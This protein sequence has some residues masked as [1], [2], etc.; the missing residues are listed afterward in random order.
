VTVDQLKSA[1]NYYPTTE[2]PKLENP[3]QLQ[4]KL[5][6]KFDF[7]DFK[8]WVLGQ[9]NKTRNYYE[10]CP[11]DWRLP[12]GGG[13]L[14][15]SKKE[16][17]DDLTIDAENIQHTTDISTL[18]DLIVR[19]PY[20]GGFKPIKVSML[21][22]LYARSSPERYIEDKQ[23]ELRLSSRHLTAS[24]LGE[25]KHWL[26][27]DPKTQTRILKQNCMFYDPATE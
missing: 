10:L 11:E 16:L 15:M 3:A 2:F 23:L 1:K 26:L 9:V 5:G 13:V 22:S 4:L 20:G 7:E 6:Q 18:E 19:L 14:G 12:I 17:L 8:Q 25:F 21:Y 24:M 27:T